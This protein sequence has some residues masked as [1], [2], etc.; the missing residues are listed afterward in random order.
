M[1]GYCPWR[2]DKEEVKFLTI[3]LEQ[4]TDVAMRF[5][6]NP[7]LIEPNRKNLVFA[8]VPEK[9]GNTMEWSDQWL[10]LP[11]IKGYEKDDDIADVSEE[12]KK[13]IVKLGGRSFRRPGAWEIDLDYHRPVQENKNE[14]PYFSRLLLIMDDFAKLAMDF[15]LLK[16]TD[17][18]KDK[19]HKKI[20]G[21]IEKNEYL[22][23]AIKVKSPKLYELLEEIAY[24]LGIELAME[25]NLK[26]INSFKREMKKFRGV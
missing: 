3:A 2:L 7:V 15:E 5:K 17:N 1:P 4:A 24:L 10:T 16:P 14:R 12:I 21:L 20:I 11:E 26:T 9:M 13:F 23:L 25:N 22:P 19:I 18:L 8:R 6:K